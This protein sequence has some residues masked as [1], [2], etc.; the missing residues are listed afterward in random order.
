M[1]CF[2]VVIMFRRKQLLDSN[3][4]E[5]TS[6]RA[7]DTW[8]KDKRTA[9]RAYLAMFKKNEKNLTKIVSIKT[10]EIK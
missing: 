1:R 6:V 2:S 7:S 5:T 10:T 9:E 3:W 8:A 4:V